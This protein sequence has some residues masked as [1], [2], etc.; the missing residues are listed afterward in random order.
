MVR[1]RGQVMSS[2]AGKYIRPDL[3]GQNIVPEAFKRN[4][5]VSVIVQSNGRHRKPYNAHISSFLLGQNSGHKFSSQSLK[6]CNGY[7]PQ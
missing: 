2:M 5:K 3:S 6:V 4:I 7:T 1:I